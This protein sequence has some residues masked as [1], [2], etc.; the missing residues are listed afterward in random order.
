MSG[1]KSYQIV[2]VVLLTAWVMMSDSL[3]AQDR[4]RILFLLDASVSMKN[5]WKGGTKWQIA[6]KALTEI[7]D[8]VSK[9]PNVE[10]G[11][12]VFGHLSP[13]PEK[14]CRDSRLE[15]AIDSNTAKKIRKKVEEIRPKGITPLVYSIEKSALDFGNY[16]AKNILI[17]ITDGEDACDRDA[18][19]VTMILEKHNVILRPFIIGMSLQSNMVSSMRCMG[20][21]FNTNSAEEFTTTLS[22]VVSEAIAKTTVQVNLNDKNGKPMETGANMTF[23]DIESGIAKFNF[24][25]SMNARGLPDTMVLSPM[26]KYKLQIHTIPPIV[27]DNI[28]LKKNQHLVINISAPQ[29]YLNCILQG[30]ISKTAALDRIKCLVHYPGEQKTLNVQRINSKEK[31]IT[32]TYELEVMTLPRM[33][34][35]NVKI[36][37]SKTTEVLIPAPGILTINKVFEAYG[38]IFIMEDNRMKKIYDLRLKD[39]QETLTLQPGKYRLVYRSKNART[40]HTTVDKEFEVTSGGS[41]S[42]KL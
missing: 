23:Y 28:E 40:I 2:C 7:V 24:Y 8:S 10:M 16:S 14:N 15:V 32:G 30:N 42:L 6:T 5:E 26:F 33:T 25:H 39:R 12:R 29:G 38:G 34:V 17:I 36:D 11:L 22:T 18:C 1:I 20:K 19:S 9:I 41:L 35:K 3:Q 27:V 21:L 31:Y 13:E 37:Q 4:T